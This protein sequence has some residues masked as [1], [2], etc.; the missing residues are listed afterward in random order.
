MAK[1]TNTSEKTAAVKTEKIDNTIQANSRGYALLKKIQGCPN[2]SE[3]K[4]AEFEYSEDGK[5]I[6]VRLDKGEDAGQ[7]LRRGYLH[8]GANRK[9]KVTFSGKTVKIA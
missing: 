9:A 2:L 5:E 7:M 1:K 4:N 3:I 8:I 6:T